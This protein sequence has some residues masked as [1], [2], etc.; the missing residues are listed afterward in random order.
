MKSTIELTDAERDL[1]LRI[2]EHVNSFKETS[3]F[4]G[5]AGPFQLKISVIEKVLLEKLPERFWKKY[6]NRLESCV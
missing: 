6:G 2:L 3:K 1:V 4:T 5:V